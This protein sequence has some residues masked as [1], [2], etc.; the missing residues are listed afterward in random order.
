MSLVLSGLALKPVYG[1]VAVVSVR[2]SHSVVF[3][4]TAFPRIVQSLNKSSQVLSV[5]W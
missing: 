1:V 4:A 3:L 5:D 2:L